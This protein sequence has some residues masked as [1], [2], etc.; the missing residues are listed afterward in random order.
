M[1][2]ILQI[3]IYLFIGSLLFSQE[4]EECVCEEPVDVWFRI[5]NNESHRY[6]ELLTIDMRA[7]YAYYDEFYIYLFVLEKNTGD[8]LVIM[9][10][11]GYWEVQQIVKPKEL[12]KEEEEKFDLD[13]YLKQN[14]GKGVKIAKNNN[15]VG[16]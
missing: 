13:E 7:G 3:V 12:P 2:T 8:E 1:K 10:P 14:K 5:S 15:K 4:C 16:E 9:F 11:I 6:G